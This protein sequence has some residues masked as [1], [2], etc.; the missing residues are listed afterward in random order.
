MLNGS[1]GLS[2]NTGPS[3]A[4][5]NT[6]SSE[7]NTNT[8]P[9]DERTGLVQN[10]LDVFRGATLDSLR[11]SIQDCKGGM[12]RDIEAQKAFVAEAEA[13]KLWRWISAGVGRHC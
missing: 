13:S 4:H 12:K 3:G 1:N 10:Y 8:E 6:Q 11:G 5:T 2:T 9:I 7:E